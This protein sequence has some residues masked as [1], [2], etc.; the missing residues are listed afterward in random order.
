MK[1]PLQALGIDIGEAHVVAAMREGTHENSRIL[2]TR[3]VALPDASLRWHKDALR[4]ALAQAIAVVPPHAMRALKGRV[5][6]GIPDQEVFPHLFV[7][8]NASLVQQ[9]KEEGFSF[10]PIDRSEFFAAVWHKNPKKVLFVAVRRA[11]VE[12]ITT[13]FREER[14]PLSVIEPRSAGIRRAASPQVSPR[15]SV[16]VVD[17]GA[18]RATLTLYAEDVLRVT[19]TFPCDG[20]ACDTM[21][22]MRSARIVRFSGTAPDAILLSGVRAHDASLHEYLASR[23]GIAVRPAGKSQEETERVAAE[24]CALR[25][26]LVDPAAEGI[27]LLPRSGAPSV[28]SALAH[29][30]FQRIRS[31]MRIK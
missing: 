23:A 27:N 17:V 18:S 10:I 19:E 30:V 22:V 6:V 25:G 29:N 5:V 2:W 20:K 28:L 9:W 13:A 8:Q 12:S 24:G 14:L 11:V 4:Q 21:I 26:L 3:K 15:E 7:V 16:L 31:K 1:S